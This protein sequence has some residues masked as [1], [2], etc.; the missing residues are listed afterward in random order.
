MDRRQRRL[1]RHED[2]LAPLLER[3]GRGAVDEVLHRAG[4]ERPDGRHRAGADDVGVDARRPARV[5]AAEVVLAVDGDLRGGARRRTARAPPRARAKDP[6]RARSRA[7]RS[8]SA[9]PLSPISQSTAASARRSRSAYGAPDAP[10]TPRKTRTAARLRRADAAAAAYGGVTSTTNGIGRRSPAFWPAGCR[11]LRRS[12]AVGRAPLTEPRGA[13]AGV[14]ARAAGDGA[15]GGAP[16]AA[17]PADRRPLRRHR[18][19]S[20]WNAWPATR[21]SEGSASS[22]RAP[23]R[24]ATGREGEARVRRRPARRRSETP[25]ELIARAYTLATEAAECDKYLHGQRDEGI[26]VMSETA[27]HDRSVAS[28]SRRPT[29]AATRTS[30]NASQVC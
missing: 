30:A 27:D 8:P 6:G 1:A 22:G 15:L 24:G 29:R 18:R 21:F 16:D 9:T 5:R 17:A 12:R 14:S 28:G 20:S 13:M 3:D 2:E 23:R 19:G 25:E 4:R 26:T 10:V 7:P 11:C